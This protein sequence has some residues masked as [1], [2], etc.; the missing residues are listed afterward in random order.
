MPPFP[1]RPELHESDNQ[2]LQQFF[3]NRLHAEIFPLTSQEDSRQIAMGIS[4]Q[5]LRSLGVRDSG[6]FLNT[7]SLAALIRVRQQNKNDTRGFQQEY[8]REL[9]SVSSQFANMICGKVEFTLPNPK[10]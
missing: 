10:K 8:D 1:P 5:L 7:D 6:V 4:L 9:E 2:K 3:K